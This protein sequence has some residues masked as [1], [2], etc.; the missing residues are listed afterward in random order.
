MEIPKIMSPLS[1]SSDESGYVSTH[2]A[3]KDDQMLKV[4][5]FI[6]EKGFIPE[7]LVDSEVAWFYK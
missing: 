6:K 1:L 5:S 3:G 4:Y 2:F 7:E